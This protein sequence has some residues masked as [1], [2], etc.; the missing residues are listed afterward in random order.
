MNK[1]LII[2]AS[3]C[4]AITI[5]AIA[6]LGAPRKLYGDPTGEVTFDLPEKVDFYKG[7]YVWNCHVK[8]CARSYT[9]SELGVEQNDEKIYYCK[10]C[11]KEYI[12]EESIEK[13]K[14]I[15]KEK[16]QMLGGI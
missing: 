14:N 5:L 6:Y 10:D 4:L 11:G 8:Q 16:V 2:S 13:L 12:T 15:F 3:I 9:Q 7:E 1:K